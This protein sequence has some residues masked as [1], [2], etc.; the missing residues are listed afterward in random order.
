[1]GASVDLTLER[2]GFY[3]AGGGRIAAR[4]EPA[5]A[6]RPISLLE[7]GEI[8]SRRAVASVAALSG[9][10][11]K[12]ELAVVAEKL[13]WAEESLR[14]VQLEDRVGPGNVLSIEIESEHVTEVF[15]GFGERGVSAETVAQRAAAQVRGYL[16]ADVPVWEHLADQLLVPMAMAGGGE[17]RT[18][19]LSSHTRT[20]TSIVER[21][22]DITVRT[23]SHGEQETHLE[24]IG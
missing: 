14:I 4:I 8:R 19:P 13:G 11:A 15:T 10:I 17:F 18:G 12:R 23:A 3:P 9:E 6:L 21:F 20:N 22:L 24:L 2:H 5:P 7:R 16:R 1:M